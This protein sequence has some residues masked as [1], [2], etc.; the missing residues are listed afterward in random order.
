MKEEY[1]VFSTNLQFYMDKLGYTQ[2][3]L[4]ELLDVSNTTVSTWC[5]GTKMPRMKTI[6]KLCDLFNCNRSDL[7]ES[8]SDADTVHSIR[9]PVLGRVAAGYPTGAIED[10]VD[11]VEVPESW[12]G[13]FFALKVRGDSMRPMISEDDILIVK[14]QGEAETGDI[15]IAQVN[16]DDATVKKIV[17][18]QNGMSLQPFNPAYDTIFYTWE[19]AKNLPV[20]ILG[21]VIESR[22]RFG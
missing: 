22:H 12:H 4:G 20:T 19:Q 8:R 11:Y 10:I 2:M 14:R 9:I 21:K 5:L 16:G 18:T 13:E 3:K 6:D 17:I 7:V 15:V 1:R